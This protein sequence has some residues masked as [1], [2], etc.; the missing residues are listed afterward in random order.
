VEQIGE[1]DPA[2]KFRANSISDAVDDLG[3]IL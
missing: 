3:A 2:Q 1:T